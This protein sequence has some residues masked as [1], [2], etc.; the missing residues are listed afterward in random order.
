MNTELFDQQHIFIPVLSL[1]LLSLFVWLAMYATRFKAIAAAG[2][3]AQEL[4]TPEELNKKL[5]TYTRNISN[6][7]K[8]L[9][10]VPVLFFVLC[11]YLYVTRQ[12]DSL[13]LNLA[14][15]FCLLRYIHSIIQCSY[16]NV[17][18]RFLSYALGCLLLWFMLLRAIMAAL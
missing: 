1:L 10:E 11:I 7:F 4:A 14:W 5:P 2:I 15:G 12:V 9:F 17:N 8:N 16:N 3:D 13:Y 18:H 6:N